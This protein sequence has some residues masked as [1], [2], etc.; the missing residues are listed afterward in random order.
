MERR[1]RA[2]QERQEK[3]KERQYREMQ[4]RLRKKKEKK[5]G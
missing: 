5:T 2:A 1:T 3:T 4:D